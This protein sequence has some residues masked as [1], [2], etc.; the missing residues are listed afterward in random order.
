MASIGLKKPY[1][2]LYKYENGVVSYEDGGIMA[3]AIEFSATI[4][5]GEDNVL[6]ADDA[7]AEVDRSFGGGS[8]TITTADLEPAA[9]AV[10]L[11]LKT[12]SVSAGG[13][14]VTELIYDDDMSAPDIGFGIIIP[15]K[16]NGVKKYRAIVFK[17][18]KFNIPEDAATTQGETIEWKTPTIEGAIMRDDSATH[19][20]KCEATFS[21]ESAAAVYIEQKLGI[22]AKSAPVASSVQSGTYT[23]AQNVALST[24]EPLGTI[25]YTLNGTI[26]SAT[27]GELYDDPIALEKPSNTC[28]KA[29]CVTTGKA[30]SDILE[31]YI[32]VTE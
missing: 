17:K 2:A 10:L 3:K 30:D 11:G 32:E 9:S 19:E 27:N 15:K 31:L 23:T 25:Y 20:W 18:A 21:T 13:E 28:I 5:S 12:Q 22:Q 16:V 7:P 26:P 1:Y 6:Y 29:V 8:L 4:E 14:S 24:T